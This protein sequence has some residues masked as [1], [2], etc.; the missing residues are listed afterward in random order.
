MKDGKKHPF[1]E[2]QIAK[3]ITQNKGTG[4]SVFK[5]RNQTLQDTDNT[6]KNN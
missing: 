4:A 5:I 1:S 2:K 6:R 3:S